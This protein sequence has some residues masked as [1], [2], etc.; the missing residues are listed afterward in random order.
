MAKSITNSDFSPEIRRAKID[1][2]N[3]YEI[4]EGELETLEKGSPG[5]IFLN[6]SIFLIGSAF[7]LL[8]A[9]LT[10]D[11]RSNITYSVFIVL[12]IIGFL[13]GV[14]L[15][16]LWYKNNKSISRL[17]DTIRKRLPREELPNIE[18]IE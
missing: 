8:V 11:I 13:A 3:I 5:S 4:S 12:I 15:L 14:M 17:V 7:T 10:T 16:I 6:F 18:I 1:C 2:L 9:L